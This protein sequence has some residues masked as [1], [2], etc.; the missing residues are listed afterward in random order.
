MGVV[1]SGGIGRRAFLG[2]LAGVAVLG[3]CSTNARVG[4]A[5]PGATHAANAPEFTPTRAWVISDS[6]AAPPSLIE[7]YAGR[8]SIIPGEVLPLFVS[9]RADSWGVR[10][11]RIGAYDG[12]GGALVAEA[13]PFRGRLQGGPRS[14][15]RTRMVDAPWKRSAELDTAGWP[16]G[17]YLIHLVA[18]GKAAYVPLVVRS[19]SVEGRVVV[20]SSVTT[21]A[22]YNLWGGRNLYG[23]ES[24]ILEARSYAVSLDRPVASANIPFLMSYEVSL[25]RAAE[26][27]GVPLAWMTN[28]DVALDPKVIAGARGLVSPGHDEYWPVPYRNALVRLRE[29]G[30]NLAFVGA[31]AGYWRVRLEDTE[32]GPGRR[33]VCY[34]SAGLDP[35]AG[36][37]DTTTRWRDSP[38]AQPENEVV[39]MLY[40]AFPAKGNMRITDPDFFLF[41]DT[42]VREGQTLL[43]LVGDEID[44]FY[45]LE[46]TP[47][48][49][50]LPAVSPV[51][52]RGSRTWSTMSYYTTA[53]GAGVF[54]TGTMNWTRALPR[55][56][57]STGDRPAK[58]FVGAV[59]GNLLR[60]MAEGPMGRRHPARDDSQRVEL[61]A[62]NTS[63]A[64]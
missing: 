17:Q 22:A 27:A 31:N 64:A 59:T 25:A 45:P 63:G 30:G 60:E 33:I 2:S 62:H 20:I 54:A 47:R 11:Y 44:R 43:N 58:E 51:T 6:N 40:D 39:G 9:T 16:E 24:K 61:P 38:R 53:S 14:D 3:A 4:D 42:G 35:R 36:S 23:N 7:G 32:N 29:E 50:Q 12:K 57:G 37:E 21:M 15:S 26:S 48:P 55:A 10:V 49:I 13:G 5:P 34:K 28:V 46:N 19:T 56:D 41:V 52:C 8:E 1:E 18:G